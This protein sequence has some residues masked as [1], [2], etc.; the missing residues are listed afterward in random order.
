MLLFWLG[1]EAPRWNP[2]R[3][4]DGYFKTLHYITHKNK[5]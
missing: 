5:I 1:L 4:A 2:E 3:L